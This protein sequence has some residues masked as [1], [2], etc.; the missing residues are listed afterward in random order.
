MLGKDGY[1]ADG[2]KIDFTARVPAGAGMRLTGDLWGLELMRRYLEILA[3]EAR[4]V[5][6]DALIMTHTPHPYLADVTDM[7][8][9][10]DINCAQDV[11]R[12]M[13]I[14]ARVAR[15]ACPEAVIDTDNWPVAS[16]AEWRK[17][18]ALQPELGVPS[19]YF[20]NAID[21]SREPLEAEDYELI[22]EVW[23][24]HRAGLQVRETSEVPG[25]RS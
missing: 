6:P 14:R 23:R 9:L 17:Y 18:L 11:N 24:Q 13:T 4:L 20:A 3:S 16:R 12:A 10:N 19:L 22:R 2:F 15:I 25:W 1:N 5:K 7:I 21:A 8:R